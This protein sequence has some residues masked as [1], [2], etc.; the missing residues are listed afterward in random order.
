MSMSTPKYSYEKNGIEDDE[1]DDLLSNDSLSGK[2][3]TGLRC[4]FRYWANVVVYSSFVIS[5]A[6][7][8]FLYL[9]GRSHKGCLFGQEA[10]Y[11]NPPL[12]YETVIF[13]RAG[14]HDRAHDHRTVYEGRPND[15]N[16]R[17]WERLMSGKL[18][19][20]PRSLLRPNEILVVGIASISEKEDSKLVNGSAKSRRNPQEHIVE[21]EVFH[22]LHC[23]VST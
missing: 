2:S 7:F 22:Q 6:S 8:I 20:E 21:L 1:G 13:Q 4:R 5:Y 17:A 3:H 18:Q 23:L 12:K 16:N 11:E 14:F 9:N 15:E 19:P 10:I